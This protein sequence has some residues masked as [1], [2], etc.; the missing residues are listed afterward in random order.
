MGCLRNIFATIGC[1]TVL[2]LAGAVSWQFRA[3]L[4]D[5]YRDFASG[6]PQSSVETSG[7]PSRNALGAARRKSD[8][9]GAPGGPAYVVLTADEMASL[10]RDGLA[11]DAARA[12]DSLTVSL[13]TG[14]LV[15]DASLVTDEWGARTLGPFAGMLGPREPVRLAGPA[16]VERAGEVAWEP[17]E[18]VV[19]S[20]PFPS[21]AIPT[22][23]NSLAQVSDGTVR[24]QV[25]GAVGDISVRPEGVT[26]YRRVP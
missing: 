5:A 24:F 22:L 15:L 14:R 3:E 18:F 17:D 1:V 19:R 4:W 21:P 13:E 26:L 25:G 8:R 20:L 12:L 16:R 10:V 2:I 23:V 6:G 7:V 11:P 9:L